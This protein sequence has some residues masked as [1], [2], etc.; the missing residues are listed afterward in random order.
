MMQQHVKLSIDMLNNKLVKHS[1]KN[2]IYFVI[3][4]VKASM[5]VKFIYRSAIIIVYSL[6]CCGN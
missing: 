6:Q 3:F 5:K 1:C 2:N 4:R